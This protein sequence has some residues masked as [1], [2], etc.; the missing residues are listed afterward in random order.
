MTAKASAGP[1]G[2]GVGLGLGLGGVGV[3]LEVGGWRRRAVTGSYNQHCPGA[4]SLGNEH[5]PFDKP[6]SRMSAFRYPCD[7]MDVESKASGRQTEFQNHRL[8]G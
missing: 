6:T 5:F 4:P 1:V 2:V 7:E 8:A 3:E